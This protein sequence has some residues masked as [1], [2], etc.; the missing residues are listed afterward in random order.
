MSRSTEGPLNFILAKRMLMT[1]EKSITNL[2]LQLKTRSL[3]THFS[4][5]RNKS[6]VIQELPLRS[7]LLKN[8]SISQHHRF[9]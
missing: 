9:K 1:L 6:R 2:K 5:K 8:L 7:L 3:K 4:R